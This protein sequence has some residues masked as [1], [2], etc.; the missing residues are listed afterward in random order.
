[1]S[2]APVEP[3][4]GAVKGVFGPQVLDVGLRQ[5]LLRVDHVQAG[6]GEFEK[7][8]KDYFINPFP[9]EHISSVPWSACDV[10]P[11]NGALFSVKPTHYRTDSWCAMA[12]YTFY[13]AEEDIYNKYQGSILLT[14]VRLLSL[15]DQE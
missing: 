13:Y 6:D 8:S 1:M 12:V 5:Q 2:D 14:V 3:G 15:V 4:F 7:F 11:M 9:C 10:C